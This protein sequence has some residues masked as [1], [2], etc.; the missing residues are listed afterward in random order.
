MKVKVQFY[1]LPWAG[2]TIFS[3]T[4][5][6]GYHHEAIKLGDPVEVEVPIQV[7]QCCNRPL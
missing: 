2:D 1:K 3:A 4:E 6:T 7:C 5:G